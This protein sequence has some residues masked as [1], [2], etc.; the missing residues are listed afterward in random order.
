MN[1]QTWA[2]VSVIISALLLNRPQRLVMLVILLW[3]IVPGVAGH[4][5]TGMVIGTATPI[6]PVHPVTVLAA[7][8]LLLQVVFRGPTALSALST[9][10]GPIAAITLVV[11]SAVGQ[12]VYLGSPNGTALMLDQL[13]GGLFL[14]LLIVIASSTAPRLLLQAA[15][16]WVVLAASEGVLGLLV[17]SGALTQPFESDFQKTVWYSLGTGRQSGTFDHPLA[18]AL[19]CAMAVPLLVFIRSSVIQLALLAGITS[20]VVVSQSRTGLLLLVLGV[21]YLAIAS[22]QSIGRKFVIAVG[23]LA[24]GV[25]VAG[26]SLFAETQ[27]RFVQDSG[28]AAARGLARA[29]FGRHWE[30]FFVFGDGSGSSYRFAAGERLPSSLENGWLMYA[31][32]YGLLTT[33]L[34]F[35]ALIGPALVSGKRNAPFTISLLIGAFSVASYSSIATDT[36]AGP[37]LFVAAALAALAPR[38]SLGES[39]AGLL[40]AAADKS[41]TAARPRVSYPVAP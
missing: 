17:K 19:F 7:V 34:L 38:S 4:Q 13:A 20:G 15:R 23:T 36:I 11:A 30:S 18:L 27:G 39:E 8:A 3:A 24:G 32:D 10:R 14:Y 6:P 33:L 12:T 9:K 5:L 2:A 21:L 41:A 22:S 25:Y 1:L 29:A 26:T 37:A 35:L 40:E 16:L 31:V 28:S